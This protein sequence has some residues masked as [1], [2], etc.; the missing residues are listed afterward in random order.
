MPLYLHIN[1]NPGYY[2]RI[3]STPFVSQWT[4]T[5]PNSASQNRLDE[6]PGGFSK[7]IEGRNLI[8]WFARSGMLIFSR[9]G[10]HHDM[11]WIDTVSTRIVHSN[12]SLHK[13]KSKNFDCRI[14]DH[15][16]WILHSN[17]T[18]PFMIICNAA[19]SSGLPF[20]LFSAVCSHIPFLFIHSGH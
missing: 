12:P 7:S 10:K 15:G 2:E 11:V 6:S 17:R 19:A 1:D 13:G 14:L 20:L 4:A 18:N 5:C 8:N 9:E 16:D 3:Q